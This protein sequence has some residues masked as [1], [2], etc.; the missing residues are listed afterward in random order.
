MARFQA[1]EAARGSQAATAGFD[2]TFSVPKSVSVPWGW[3]TRR[4]M[5]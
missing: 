1:Q 3:R 5:S 2:L 4:R